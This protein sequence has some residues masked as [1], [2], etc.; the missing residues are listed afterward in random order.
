MNPYGHC[1]DFRDTINYQ[2]YKDRSKARVKS[3]FFREFPA[4]LVVRIL[5]FHCC[6]PGSIPGCR[7]EIPQAKKNRNIFPPHNILPLSILT[8]KLKA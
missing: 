2:K 6:G 3:T 7:T 5:G 4:G 8:L 1:P